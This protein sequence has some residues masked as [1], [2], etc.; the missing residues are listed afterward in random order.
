MVW[1]S[2]SAAIPPE[3]QHQLLGEIQGPLFWFGNGVRLKFKAIP[4]F[5]VFL[6]TC[7]NEEDPLKTKGL[8]VSQHFF[9][10]KPM[11]FFQLF[12]GS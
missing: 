7:K 9:H 12:K 11:G 4:A 5:I 3:V 8:D 6:V 10:N 2:E 1:L